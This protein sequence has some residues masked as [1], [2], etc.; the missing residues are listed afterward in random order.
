MATANAG[1]AAKGVSQA[2]AHFC[3]ATGSRLVGRAGENKNPRPGPSSCAQ[4]QGA[5][6][7]RRGVRVTEARRHAARPPSR[8]RRS[9]PRER[10]TQPRRQSVS[11]CR[12]A[13]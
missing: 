3:A 10:A 1:R 5:K 8:E 7:D 11:A 4:M 6:H 2:P 12:L 9:M 13:S